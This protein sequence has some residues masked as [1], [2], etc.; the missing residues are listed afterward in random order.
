M[1]KQ[2]EQHMADIR[3][4]FTER[5]RKLSHAFALAQQAL[6]PWCAHVPGS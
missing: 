3:K 6:Q 4:N 2:I 1:K 5:E